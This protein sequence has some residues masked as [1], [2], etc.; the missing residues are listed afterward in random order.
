[1]RSTAAR[2]GA[3]PISHSRPAP[4]SPFYLWRCGG[5]EP[6]PRVESL[7]T[8]WCLPAPPLSPSWPR[9]WPS[10][11]LP[12]IRGHQVASPS[13]TQPRTA[14]LSPSPGPPRKRQCV[15]CWPLWG[16]PEPPLLPLSGS[17]RAGEVSLGGEAG[18]KDTHS[19]VALGG[20]CNC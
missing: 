19:P 6:T 7:R 14:C 10:L 12:G 4:K 9:R 1:M 8:A 20:L 11:L 3:A 16:K 2:D 13:P 15:C 18:I 5:G 17:G